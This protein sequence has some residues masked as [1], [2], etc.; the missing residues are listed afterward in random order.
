MNDLSKVYTEEAVLL[1][2]TMK[3]LE[4]QVRDNI[5]A[6]RICDRYAKGYSDIFICVNGRLVLAELKDDTGHP[7]PHQLL[8]IKKMRKAGAIGGICRSI[9]DVADLIDQAKNIK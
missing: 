1:R 6:L 9:Q 8:F 5:V 4:P 7:S 3:W 2:K